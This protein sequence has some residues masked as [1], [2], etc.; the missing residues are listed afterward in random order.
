MVG[1]ASG[2]GRTHQG[3][4]EEI[5]VRS[6][7]ERL[8]ARI[9]FDDHT[10]GLVTGSFPPGGS[11]GGGSS[12]PPTLHEIPINSS[13]SSVST[14]VLGTFGGRGKAAHYSLT[15]AAGTAVAMTLT[16]GTATIYQDNSGYDLVITASTG[17]G[18]VLSV[19]THKGTNSVELA[20]ISVTGSIKSIT[21]KSASLTG[22]MAV[23]GT[24]G[25]LAL[26]AINGTIGCAGGSIGAITAASLTDANILSGA[27]L[28]S[29]G[30]FYAAGSI[31]SLTVT[32]SV[33][34]SLIGAGYNANNNQVLGGTS[35]VIHTIVVKKTTDSSTQ[36]IAGAFGTAKLP[37]PI[38]IATDPRFES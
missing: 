5:A 19:T 25:T 8:E 16:G 37:K 36:F 10:G 35:S 13:T 9:V 26:G 29:N 6:C 27:N 2:A 14:P 12:G 3:F 20:N 4:F 15:T 23:S 18:A 33:T 17:P 22:A 28:S 1:H 21:A 30:N 11:S 32:G 38:H 7:I 24:I 34:H 31:G